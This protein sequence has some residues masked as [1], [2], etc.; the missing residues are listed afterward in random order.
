MN[1]EDKIL[2][3]ALSVKNPKGKSHAPAGSPRLDDAASR[4]LA[5]LYKKEADHKAREQLITG[6]QH[7]LAKQALAFSEQPVPLE[8][9]VEAARPALDDAADQ[10]D[11]AQVDS[12]SAFAAQLI[13]ARLN[14]YLRQRTADGGSSGL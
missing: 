14:A 4:K 2:V 1:E 5:W 6:S 10:W 11:P 8:E 7:L 9:L 12:F 3:E 13:N